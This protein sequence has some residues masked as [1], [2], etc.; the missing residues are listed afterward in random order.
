MNTLKNFSIA[1]LS[2]ITLGFAQDINQAKKAVDAEQYDKAK[3]YW[4]ECLKLNPNHTNA[5]A[6]LSTIIVVPASVNTV[7]K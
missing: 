5:K 2:S 7:K 4:E 1:F 6:G 3:Y